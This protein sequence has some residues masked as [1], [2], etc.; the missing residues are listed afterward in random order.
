MGG[1]EVSLYWGWVR[2]LETHS[3]VGW[4]QKMEDAAYARPSIITNNLVNQQ[5]SKGIS[6][7]NYTNGGNGG[8]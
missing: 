4:F 1:G 3:A 8:D 6:N 7:T 2:L 5:R